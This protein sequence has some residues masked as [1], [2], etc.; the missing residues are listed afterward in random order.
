MRDLLV[1]FGALEVVSLV[2]ESD[3]AP[4]VVRNHVHGH[5]GG[6]PVAWE[7]PWRDGTAVRSATR[8]D[9]LRLLL[10]AQHLP[11]VDAIT[12]SAELSRPRDGA[13]NFWVH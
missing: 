13:Q 9:L 1:E 5:Q 4:F 7:V 10:S 12:G 3:T 11:A 2:F 6:G 8:A